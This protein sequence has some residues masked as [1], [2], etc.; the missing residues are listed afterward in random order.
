MPPAES[1]QPF[2]LITPLGQVQAG[3]LLERLQ[4]LGVR[5]VATGICPHWSYNTN[6]LRHPG[7][8]SQRHQAFGVAWQTALR[9]YQP[10]LPD[11]ALVWWLK[12]EDYPIV[13]AAKA[14]LRDG[15]PVHHF[16]LRDQQRQ[17]TTTL[18]SLHVP[19][20]EDLQAEYGILK[21]LLQ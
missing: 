13:Q 6:R 5:P 19:D 4:A 14:A 12:A 1:P 9:A 20:P 16:C 15:L 7:V 17:K 3:L 18:H 2:L 21:S 10:Q 8:D 11:Q